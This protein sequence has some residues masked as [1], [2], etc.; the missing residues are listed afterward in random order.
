MSRDNHAERQIRKLAAERYEK[1]AAQGDEF[2]LDEMIDEL[3]IDLLARFAE[4]SGGVVAELIRIS[5]RDAVRSV[6]KEQTKPT[7]QPTLSAELDHVIPV[8]DG[9]RR[10]RRSMDHQN[11]ATHLGYIADN[12]ARVNERAGKEN[13]RYA[14]LAPY[15]MQGKNTE[16]ALHAWSAD[17]P[18]QELS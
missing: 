1:T 12:A 14:A 6:D 10:E 11:W 7:M 13:K 3:I 9:R 8:G 18:E 16:G 17:N 4:D 2:D 5:A 15:L